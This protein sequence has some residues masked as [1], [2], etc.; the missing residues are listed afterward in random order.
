MLLRTTMDVSLLNI[1]LSGRNFK[2]YADPD[3]VTAAGK[4]SIGSR[5]QEIMDAGDVSTPEG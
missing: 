4:E 1:P 3:A 5:M 2:T